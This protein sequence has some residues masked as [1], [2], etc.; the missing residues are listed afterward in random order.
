MSKIENEKVDRA[1]QALVK[2]L[3]QL[4][5]NYEPGSKDIQLRQE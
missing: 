3:K 1:V 2:Q 5:S 4:D